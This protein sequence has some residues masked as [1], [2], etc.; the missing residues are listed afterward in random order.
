MN[1]HR[2]KQS[3]TG[4]GCADLS[5]SKSVSFT[6]RASISSSMVR[7]HDFL[8]AY[9]NHT[10]EVYEHRQEI[11]IHDMLSSLLLYAQDANTCT[12][13]HLQLFTKYQDN[14]FNKHQTTCSMRC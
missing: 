6:G 3:S 9:L 5:N 4:I 2:Q 13:A 14:K 10:E 12:F 11:I 1:V 7:E 8:G